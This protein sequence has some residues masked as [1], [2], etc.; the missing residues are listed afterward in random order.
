MNDLF[1]KKSSTFE[2]LIILD[3]CKQ[4]KS[5][6]GLDSLICLKNSIKFDLMPWVCS[7]FGDASYLVLL[8][9]LFCFWP[10][11]SLFLFCPCFLCLALFSYFSSFG[12]VFPFF[13]AWPCF[14]IFPLLAL[15]SHF[16]SFGL[17]FPFFLFC[18]FSLFFP[19]SVCNVTSS[20]L[21]ALSVS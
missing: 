10:C 7:A 3:I 9:R 4:T 6:Y 18:L 17:V 8:S 14:P 16:S 21:S 12:L 5:K 11:F 20:G 1:W 15:S 13:F 19:I 2:E